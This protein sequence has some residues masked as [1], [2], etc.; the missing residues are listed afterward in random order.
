MAPKKGDSKNAKAAEKAK[1]EAKKKVAEDKTF[2]LKNKNKSKV[3][4][5][6]V[7]QVHQSVNA[8]SQKDKRLEA[9]KDPKKKKEAEK[10]VQEE[11]N[12]LFQVAIKQ[13]K[14][15]PGVDP[16]SIMCEYYKRGQC[17]KGFKCKFSH[18]RSVERKGEKVDIYSDMRDAKRED[19]DEEGMEGWDQETLEKAVKQKHGGE[20]P[21]Q[22]KIICKH[23]LEALENKQ[24]GW[25]WVCPNGGKNCQYRHALPPGY[26]LKSQMKQLMEEEMANKKS[27]EE[28]IEEERQKVEARTPLTEEVFQGW[29]QKKMAE[30]IKQEAKKKEDRI[31]A[32]RYTGREIFALEGFEAVDDKSASEAYERERTA[33]EEEAEIRETNRIA[34]EAY[35]KARAAAGSQGGKSV[36]DAPSVRQHHE[37]PEALRKQTEEGVST[38][39]SSEAIPG[40]QLT[41]EEED[42]FLGAL[43]VGSDTIFLR[44]TPYPQNLTLRP[45]CRR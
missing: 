44:R 1:A 25:F 10:K 43:A 11:L 45:V 21:N 3:V 2:G 8:K 38:A 14:V 23:F 20:K 16:K 18:D 36:L 35:E 42:L 37:L 5:S 34:A 9:E 6:Y 17:T 31:K 26:V 4:K 28:E 39:E 30:R 40:L 27:V 24:Y 33:E 12:D 13:P 7:Q 22:T 32:Q 15:P 19:E 41:K 29:R